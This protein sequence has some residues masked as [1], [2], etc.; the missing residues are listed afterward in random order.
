MEQTVAD[1]VKEHMLAKVLTCLNSGLDADYIGMCCLINNRVPVTEDF[2]NHEFIPTVGGTASAI[3]LI[4]GVLGS[5]GLPLVC[6]VWENNMLL[7]FD[8]YELDND[9]PIMGKPPEGLKE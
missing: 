5:I 8:K 4:N 3:G 7:G 1:S 6:S 2:Q 9:N